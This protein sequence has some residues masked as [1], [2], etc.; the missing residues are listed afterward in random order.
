VKESE[1]MDECNLIFDSLEDMNKD[2]EHATQNGD[3]ETT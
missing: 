2:V 3:E 1:A